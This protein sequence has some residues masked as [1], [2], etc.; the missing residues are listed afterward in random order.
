MA[1]DADVSIGFT[2]VGRDVTRPMN[3][4][5]SRTEDRTFRP[6]PRDTRIPVRAPRYDRRFYPRS[7]NR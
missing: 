1:R 7:A 5:L 3:V 6:L 2:D 4:E